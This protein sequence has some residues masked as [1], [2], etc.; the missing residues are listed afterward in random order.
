[1]ILQ[2]K[3]D[4]TATNNYNAPP[5]PDAKKVTFK[6]EILNQLGAQNAAADDDAVGDNFDGIPTSN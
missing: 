6:T 2:N 1:M 3:A 4:E 5:P